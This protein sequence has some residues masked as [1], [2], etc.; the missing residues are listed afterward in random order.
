MR[1]SIGWAVESQALK[2]PTKNTESAPGAVQ[3]KLIGLA[4]LRAE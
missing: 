4:I 2:S 1:L 3:K